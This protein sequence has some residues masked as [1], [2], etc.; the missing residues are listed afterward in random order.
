MTSFAI[1]AISLAQILQLGWLV[2]LTFRD[3][4]YAFQPSIHDEFLRLQ[5]RLLLK[6]LKLEVVRPGEPSGGW[7]IRRVK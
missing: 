3:D 7:K 5:M 1:L 2:W 6:K 4:R